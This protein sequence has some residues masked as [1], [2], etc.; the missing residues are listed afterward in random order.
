MTKP[1]LTGYGVVNFGIYRIWPRS[2]LRTQK[3]Q[4]IIMNWK[5]PA[6]F[7]IRHASRMT[8]ATSSRGIWL[9]STPAQGKISSP[10]QSQHLPLP[11]SPTFPVTTSTIF[12]AANSGSNSFSLGT[13]SQNSRLKSVLTVPG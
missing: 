4:Y 1:H 3:V 2:K 11:S 8:S 7:F 9:P 5:A 12:S 13:V 6:V 10:F